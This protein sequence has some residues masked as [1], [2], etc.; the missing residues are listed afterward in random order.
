MNSLPKKDYAVNII[1]SN[2][3][4]LG[5]FKKNNYCLSK[6]PYKIKEMVSSSKY[7]PTIFFCLETHLKSFHR[8]IRLPRGLKYIGETSHDSGKGGIFCFMSNCFSIENKDR[9]V[10]VIV[11]RYA[12]FVRVKIGT[13]YLNLIPVYLPSFKDETAQILNEISK[14]IEKNNITDFCLF[15]DTNCDFMQPRHT[16]RTTLIQAFL[17][18]YNLYD[19]AGKNNIDPGYTWRGTKERIKSKSYIDHFYLNFDFF[20]Q[21]DFTHSSYSDHKFMRIANKKKF[22]YKAPKWQSYLFN[23]KDFI[24]II[25]KETSKFLIQSADPNSISNSNASYSNN[26]KL[27]DNEFTYENAE[28][29]NSGTMFDLINALKKAHDK[30]YSKMRFKAFQKTKDFDRQINLLYEMIDTCNCNNARQEINQLIQLQQEFFKELVQTQ[31]ETYQMRS[32]IIDGMPNSFTYKNFKKFKKHNH[33]LIIDDELIDCPNRVANIFGSMHAEL[34]SPKIMPVSNL[35]D[36]MNTF[37]LSLD[38]MFPRIN[39]L[40]SPYSTTSEF[41][42]VIKSMRC[43]SMPGPTTQP[44]KLFAFLFDNLPKFTTKA[45]NHMYDIDIDNSSLSFVKLRNITHIPK[46]GLDSSKP[47]NSRPLAQ[48]ENALKILDK[49]LNRKVTPLLNKICH[50]D[51][52]GFIP[53]RHMGNASISITGIINYIKSHEPECQLVFFDLK[54]AFDK[55]LHCVS[56]RI[57]NHIFPKG[58]FGKALISITNGGKFKALVGGISSCIYEN[59]IGFSQ[60]APSSGTLFDMYNHIFVCCLKSPRIHNLSLKLDGKP[61]NPTC[62]ADDCFKPFILKT[63]NDVEL[64]SNLLKKLESTVNIHINFKKTKILTQG[65]YP[66]NLQLIGTPCNVV[67]HLGVFLSF[68]LTQA[69]ELT[70]NE[71]FEKLNAKSQK[72]AFMYTDNIFKRRNICFA[73]MNTMA[74]HIFRLYS[75]KPKQIKKIWKICSKLLWSNKNINGNTHR[76]K[77]AKTRIEMDFFNGGLNMLLPAQQSFIIWFTSFLNLIRHAHHFPD[78]NIASLMSF[79]HIPINS[80]FSNLGSEIFKKYIKQFKALYPDN[81]GPMFKR[82][83]LFIKQLEKDPMT[84]LHSTI[85]TSVWSK[86]ISFSI[87][88]NIELTEQ[89]LNTIASILDFSKL[90][91][92]ILYLPIINPGIKDL[93]SSK[94]LLYTKLIKI[95]ENVRSEFKFNNLN[96]ITRS[97]QIY[98]LRPLIKLF[99]TSPKIYSF[100]FKKFNKERVQNDFIPPAIISRRNDKKYFP[101]F[102]TFKKS[103]SRILTLPITLYYKGFL[104]EQFNRTLISRNKLF[105]MNVLDS[106]LCIKCNVKADSEHSLYSC[107]FP[108]YFIHCLALFLDRYYNDGK[109]NF[110]FLK[111]NFFLYNIYYESFNEAEYTQIS[112]LVLAAKDRFLKINKDECLSRWT[113]FNCFAQTIFISQFTSKVLQNT[114]I[115]PNLT[116]EFIQFIMLYSHDV[117]FFRID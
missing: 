38:N 18:K 9:D 88:D 29:K 61:I 12:M 11:S 17:A 10:K 24:E 64:I 7:I 40:T 91:H 58:N 105:A 98:V 73:L 26:L 68:D 16:G 113:D 46:P 27:I 67:K 1:C 36:L 87:E 39:N 56:N 94:P 89:G 43:N 96:C 86:N 25:K 14:F 55:T 52:Y 28:L 57:I 50:S 44:T 23:N 21:I 70:Y 42:K 5:S 83:L 33:N 114:G 34:V 109:P 4:G 80:F 19:L 41:R 104:F 72:F 15:G 66:S 71:L 111:E 20:N 82:A 90:E 99:E 45:F 31:S 35:D 117:H 106:N 8:Q 48:M 97:K 76:H 30:F 108:K 115:L 51:Q 49:A 37:D 62:F 77:V 54:R 107:Y 95:V 6:I 100:H 69:S 74:F 3:R 81:C 13:E 78:S 22:Q 92:K 60:G 79:K 85:T 110:I 84:F 53:K 63:T 75:P 59:K 116:D 112:L 2:V 102:E 103:F 65:E 47:E 93:I 101:D 32:L